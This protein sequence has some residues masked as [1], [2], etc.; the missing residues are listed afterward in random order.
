MTELSTIS[1]SRDET[2][3]AVLDRARDRVGE[4]DKVVVLMEKK[5]G[6]IFWE[7]PPEMTLANIVWLAM[8]LVHWV[9]A[10]SRGD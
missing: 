1:G 8:A 9:Y 6:G 3:R 10:K 5:S 4:C 2:L 7:A